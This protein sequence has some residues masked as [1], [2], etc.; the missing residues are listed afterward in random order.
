[1]NCTILISPD[2]IPANAMYHALEVDP[3]YVKLCKVQQCF[4]ARLSPKPWRIGMNAPDNSTRFP[5][6][7]KE[8]DKKL[9]DWLLN[10]EN[11]AKQF[12]TVKHL[13]TLGD[14]QH[15]DIVQLLEVHD[16]YALGGAKPLA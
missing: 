6:K 7:S 1:M 15:P 12:A 11:K 8:L 10:Y 16:K 13:K 3:L 2:A 4:R 5:R 9:N 14:E